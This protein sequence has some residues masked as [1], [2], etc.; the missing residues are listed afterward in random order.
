MSNELDVRVAVLEEKCIALDKSQAR[1]WK[2]LVA[3]DEHLKDIQRTLNKIQWI[4]TGMG[5][6]WLLQTFGAEEV[7]KRMFL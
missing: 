6:L 4:A 1:M 2:N 3:M 7:L 5:L